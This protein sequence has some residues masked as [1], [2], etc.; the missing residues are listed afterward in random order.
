MKI[1]LLAVTCFGLLTGC[2]APRSGRVTV[3]PRPDLQ[4]ANGRPDQVRFLEV[5][6]AYHVGRSIDPNPAVLHEAHTIYRVEAQSTW[7]LQ[8]PPGYFLLPSSVG[9]LTNAAYAS[10]AFNEAVIAELNHQRA[11]T[12]TVSQQAASLGNSLQDLGTALAASRSLIEQN[13]ALRLQLS[14]I[15]NRLEAAESKLRA[16]PLPP[17]K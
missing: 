13:Q 12:R 1:H 2:S 10:P 17:S 4:A 16:A 5:V 8:P 3:V 14:R 7:N 11:I 6:K 15:E 9:V